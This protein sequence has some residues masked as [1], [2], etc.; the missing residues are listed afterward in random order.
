MNTEYIGFTMKYSTDGKNW[1]EYKAP[2]P[3]KKGTTVSLKLVTVSGRESRITT[4]K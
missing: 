3:V 1:L 4:V 2:A